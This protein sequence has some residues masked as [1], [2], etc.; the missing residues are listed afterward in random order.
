MKG[1]IVILVVGVLAFAIPSHATIIN[2]PANQPNIQA[3]INASSDDDTVRVAS[4]TYV[5][6]IDFSGKN[7]VVG[8]WFL[9]AGDPSYI[10]STIIDGNQAGSVVSFSNLEDNS[11]VISGKQY[12]LIADNIECPGCLQDSP[13]VFLAKFH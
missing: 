1:Y 5:E 9:D 4:G 2:V 8:S 11:A 3:G 10:S 7:I 13:E 12:Y 6:N